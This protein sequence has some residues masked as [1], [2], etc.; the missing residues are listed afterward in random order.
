MGNQASTSNPRQPQASRPV[1]T[2]SSSEPA[3]QSQHAPPSSLHDSPGQTQEIWRSPRARKPSSKG[4]YAASTQS[5]LNVY[6]GSQPSYSSC[7]D[8]EHVNQTVATATKDIHATG[9]AGT[10]KGA[11]RSSS[12]SSSQTTRKMQK[13][14]QT[15][16]GKHRDKVVDPTA[17]SQGVSRLFGSLLAGLDYDPNHG[18]NLNSK[19]YRPRQMDPSRFDVAAAGG[20]DVEKNTQSGVFYDMPEHGHPV[21]YA[22]SQPPN[23]QAAAER[24]PEHGQSTVQPYV[25]PSGKSTNYLA[26]IRKL[27]F[28]DGDDKLTVASCAP[29]SAL[30][31]CQT[32]QDEPGAE[33]CHQASPSIDASTTVE[34]RSKR[35]VSSAPP[36]SSATSTTYPLNVCTDETRDTPMTDVPDE[37]INFGKQSTEDNAIKA[38]PHPDPVSIY[39]QAEDRFRPSSTFSSSFQYPEPDNPDEPDIADGPE[40][41]DD[42]ITVCDIKAEPSPPRPDYSHLY[43]FDNLPPTRRKKLKVPSQQTTL[44]TLK[45]P[46]T[47]TA[48]ASSP[49][50]FAR[51][52]SLG[53]RR[54]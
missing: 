16:H 41:V 26:P 45:P 2:S 31:S 46:T 6:G 22:P 43:G 37:Q 5:N 9:T 54:T 4:S 48:T 17:T 13:Q 38:E 11:T 23:P 21:I 34:T 49:S 27:P 1:D 53:P 40:V 25:Y 7:E 36:A 33:G 30:D 12:A 18:K 10:K 20:R 47:T 8:T 19:K 39:K 28:L 24:I 3:D 14:K 35:T 32:S 42:S 29:A 52:T 44:S 50:T 51:P 15:Q